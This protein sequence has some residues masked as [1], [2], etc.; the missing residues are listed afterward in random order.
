MPYENIKT[1]KTTANSNAS[2]TTYTFRKHEI[3]TLTGDGVATFSAGVNETFADL[4]EKD[5][6]VSITDT[7]SGG[8]GAIGD[9]LSL[10]GNNH[11]GS[12]IF[13]LNGAKTTLT[14]DFGA[15]YASHDIKALVTVNK[16]VGTSKTKT[17]TSGSTLAVSTQATIESGVIGLAKADIKALNSVFMAPDFSTAATTSH[18]DITSRFD[19][20]DGQRDNFYDIGRI[21][22]K[23]GELTPTGR[24]LINFDY[25]THSS[26]DYFDV[27]SYSA[28]S[29]EDI[30]SYTSSTTGT[31]YELRDSLDFRPRVDDDST[32]DSGNQ[33]RSFDG[34][35]NSVVNPIKF[36]R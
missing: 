35:G 25:Y 22:L 30:P 2:D 8:T 31:R 7:G 34:T 18:T 24:L 13:S 5:F 26:G 15:N 6:T 27:D 33:D 16:T 19:L 9:V 20:D 1:L 17:L 3:K 11:E 29:Y 4:T 32:I 21:K 14:L 10:T 12:A 36:N 28:I 23:D